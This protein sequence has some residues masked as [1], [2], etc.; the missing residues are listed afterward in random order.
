MSS[1]LRK[2]FLFI[3]VFALSLPVI[4]STAFA[5][6]GSAGEP[7]EIQCMNT[8]MPYEAWQDTASPW[9]PPETQCGYMTGN[10]GGWR[11]RLAD[12]GVTFSSS[13]V[14]DVLADPVGGRKTGQTVYNHSWGMDMNVD[15]EKAAEIKGLQFHISALWRA[16]ANISH[17]YIGNTFTASSIYGSQE[18]KLYSLYLQE[19]LFDGNFDIK[20]GRTSAGDDFA[21]SP[22]Y[23]LYI[24]NAIDGNPISLPINLPFSTYP[25]AT[26]GGRALL[27]FPHDLYT[28]VGI[29][30]GDPRVGRDEAHG[31]DFSLRLKRGVFLVQ[32]V[33]YKPNQAQGSTGLPGNY[34]LG[35][36]YDTGTFRDLYRDSY[37]G[38]SV[39]S[40][41]PLAKH[42]GNYGF[43][44]HADQMIYREKEGSDQGLTPWAAITWAPGNLNQFPLFI[45]GGVFY[46]GLIPT[47][48]QDILAIGTAYGMWSNDLARL[49]QDNITYNGSTDHKKVYEM[50]FD[51]TYKVQINPWLYI[52]PDMQYILHP[53]GTGYIRDAFVI[54]TRVGI[55]F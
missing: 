37:G 24:N 48:D 50:M 10:W 28:M 55:T 17:K 3:T 19:T 5:G 43:Y 38:S 49:T 22:I 32:E 34:K 39:V 36:F 41:R 15:L 6:S 35:G 11:D 1:Y 16:G 14:M 31:C 30:D 20:I 44:A 45:D 47:R 46:K 53:G 7:E 2:L 9:S 29:Y 51:F 52:Q 25:N 42:I 26:W 23:W 13:Y 18:F 54:G 21:S 40:G 8:D 4:S 12:E 33:G 27:R